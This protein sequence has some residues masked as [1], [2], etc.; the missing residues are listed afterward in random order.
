MRV[1]R[2]STSTETY[3]YLDNC[4]VALT[5]TD[6]DVTDAFSLYEFFKVQ[7][8]DYLQYRKSLKDN[9]LP[10]WSSLSNEEKRELVK[11]NVAPSNEDKLVYYTLEEQQQNYN[12]I[13]TLEVIAR[14][15]RWNQAMSTAAFDLMGNTLHQLMMYNDAKVY[16]YDYIEADLP[17]L[18]LWLTGGAYPPL[19][20]DFSSNGYP[21]KSYFNSSTL[22]KVLQIL[23]K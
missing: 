5:S 10:I 9:R 20:I 18:V 7:Q 17:H 1:F 3:P 21:T 13:V 2:K 12:I 6:I 22:N 16:R 11:H 23:T 14:T 15:N 8:I 4:Y 19:N